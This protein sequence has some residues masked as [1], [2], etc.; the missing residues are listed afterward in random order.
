MV[1]T[2]PKAPKLGGQTDVV[3]IPQ[4]NNVNVFTLHHFGPLKEGASPVYLHME[5]GTEFILALLESTDS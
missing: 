5:D 2:T 1:L 3:I 4:D